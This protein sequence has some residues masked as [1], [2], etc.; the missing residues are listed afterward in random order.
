M[1]EAQ[2]VLG[3]TRQQVDDVLA[4]TASAPSL[5]NSQPWRFRL[6]PRTIELVA[7]RSRRLDVVDPDEGELRI[8][9]GA[10]LFTLRLALHGQGIRPLVTVLPDPA[11]P[12]L[13]AVVRH[14]GHRAPT[15]ELSRLLAAVPRRHTNRHPFSDEPVALPEQYALRRAA[16]DEGAWLH[17]V[18]DAGERAQL[19][20]MAVVAH[21]H[22][23]SD[24]A[25]R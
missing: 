15:P 13:I 2:S 25:F 20:E 3:M 16:Q 9:C 12:D 19:R 11:D 4:T 24:P 10:A 22:Q 23:L 18:D 1:D 5:H 6:G 8:S 7:D 17:V 21:R 14:G